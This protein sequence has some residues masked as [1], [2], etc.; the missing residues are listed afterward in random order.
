VT[1]ANVQ[2]SRFCD[3]GQIT[4]VLDIAEVRI[5][6]QIVR[7]T[8]STRNPD[9]RDLKCDGDYP[10]APAPDTGQ[11]FLLTQQAINKYQAELKQYTKE[12]YA[13]LATSTTTGKRTTS[14]TKA[15]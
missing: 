13:T 14:T 3:S 7:Y 2:S 12:Y 1:Y 4:T 15:K 6:A 5:G 9:F 10:N 11:L 8:L